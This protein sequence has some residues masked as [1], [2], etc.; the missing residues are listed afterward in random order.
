VVGRW[1]Y[2]P[3]PCRFPGAR[4]FCFPYAG[5]GASVFR[6]WSAGLPSEFDVC[7]V[8]LPGRTAR[9]AEPPIASVPVLVDG[10]VTAITSH[11][12]VPFV[13]FGHSMGA[14]L[15]AEVTRE[16]ARRGAPLP[17]YLIV[18]ARRPPHM[19]DPQSPLR[20]LS[21]AEFVEEIM[22]RYGG[23]PPEVLR[24]KEL[25]ALLLPA[26]R[27]DI[28][29]LET[30]WPP[31]RAPLPCPIVAFGGSDDALTPKAHLE[32]WREETVSNFEICVFPGGHFYLEPRRTAVLAK[33]SEILVRAMDEVRSR[34][35]TI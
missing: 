27:A 19:A 6:Q 34:E 35:R 3:A 14:I 7:A 9:M 22:R 21:D 17:R 28:A 8:Q 32:A 20:N 33:V 1:L 15:A 10:I 18:S 25:L 12:D 31:R 26:L 24:E 4:L 29:A 23:I 13:F 16:L 30:H 11:L 5:V 2:R